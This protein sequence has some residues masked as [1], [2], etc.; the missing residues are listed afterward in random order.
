MWKGEGRR[1]E[2]KWRGDR[3]GKMRQDKE[4]ES[5]RSPQRLTTNRKINENKKKRRGGGDGI[6][7]KG[8]QKK[9]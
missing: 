9:R 6:I 8:R 2:V 5:R 7:R 1:R 3:K 4:I